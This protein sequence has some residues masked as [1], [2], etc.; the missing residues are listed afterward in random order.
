MIKLSRRSKQTHPTE[1]SRRNEGTRNKKGKVYL[2]KIFN[3]VI[4]YDVR[5]IRLQMPLNHLQY[6]TDPTLLAETMQ[7]HCSNV[8]VIC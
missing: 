4:E 6:V 7:D 5:R 2:K 1:G 8:Y 3:K